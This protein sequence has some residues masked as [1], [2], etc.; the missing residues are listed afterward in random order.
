MAMSSTPVDSDQW[1]ESPNPNTESLIARVP[2]ALWMASVF[3]RTV[4][5]VSLLIVIVHLSMPQ[6]STI[7]TAY[8]VPSDLTRLVLGFV[9]CLWVASQLFAVPQD[10]H[11]HRTW[12]YLG[13]AAVPFT[14]ICI[15]A[16]W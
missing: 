11:A 10:R 7:W 5:I 13:A 14:L 9:A 2:T 1:A 15:V 8:D 16:I 3:L 4:F 12:L 6:S